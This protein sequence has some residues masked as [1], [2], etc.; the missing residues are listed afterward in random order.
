MSTLPREALYSQLSTNAP[1]NRL[2]RNGG[3]TDQADSLP[4]R[5]R[6]HID[7]MAATISVA[8]IGLS[9]RC[10]IGKRNPRH[11]GS[12][13]SA[14]KSSVK[15]KRSNRSLQGGGSNLIVM[16]S[17]AAQASATATIPTGI[18]NAASQRVGATR[19]RTL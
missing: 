19:T 1:P 16:P 11:A 4:Q 14:T 8:R 7:Q 2:I 9:Q 17:A 10:S 18:N 6:C 13:P 3:T 12:S 15:T 5:G